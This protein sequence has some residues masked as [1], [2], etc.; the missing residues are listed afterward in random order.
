VLDNVKL[1]NE[2]EKKNVITS[3]IFRSYFPYILLVL[4]FVAFSI[5]NSKFAQLSNIMNILEQSGVLLVVGMGMTF[6]IIAG[7]IDLS[8]GSVLGLTASIS[9][10]YINAFGPVVGVLIGILVGGICGLL[11]GVVYVKAK[12]PSFIVTLGMMT[13]AR[14]ILLIITAGMT[15]LIKSNSVRNFSNGRLFFIPNVFLVF[16]FIFIICLL[17]FD[18]T[19]FGVY[20]RAI[21]G[22]EEVA[23]FSGIDVD[24][25]KIKIFLLSGITAGIGGV[26]SAIRLGASSPN[27]G[28]GFELNVIGAVV[29]GGT[30]LSGGTGKLLGTVIGALIMGMLNNGLNIMGVNSFI[31]MVV[32]GIVV[33]VAVILTIDRKKLS[34]IVK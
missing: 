15:V 25:V 20:A 29:L 32:R 33:I 9:A 5:G 18:Y 7:G 3:E 26:L 16:I 28:T 21:G 8:V 23:K 14:G 17:L 22:N 12:I 4:L 1:K 11:N 2:V 34:G 31:Q 24:W 10:I 27:L 6:V 19:S 30:A 13:I